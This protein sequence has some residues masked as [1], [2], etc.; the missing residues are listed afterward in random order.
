M[1]Q[2][3]QASIQCIFCDDIREEAEGKTS[4]IG[5]FNGDP[6]QLPSEGPLVFPTLGIVAL[7]AIPLEPKFQ[8]VKVELVQNER[9]LHA[10]NLPSDAVVQLQSD[11]ADKEQAAGRQVRI[12]MKMVG[13]TVA[14]PGL[15]G[16]RLYLDDL[17]LDSNALHFK[18]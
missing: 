5:W 1:Q 17:Q 13:I 14:E 12:A 15:I 9:V 4:I 16:I 3:E 7:A 10:I 11:E 6:I 18:R 2:L 8:S